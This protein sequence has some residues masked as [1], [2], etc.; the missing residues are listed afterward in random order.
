LLE[1]PPIEALEIAERSQNALGL[2]LHSQEITV[3]THRVPLAG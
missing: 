1:A 3:G 2:S